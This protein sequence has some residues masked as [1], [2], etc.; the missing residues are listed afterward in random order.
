MVGRSQSDP[1]HVVSLDRKSGRRKAA[2]LWDEIL[3]M[4]M[5]GHSRLTGSRSSGD[6]LA[7]HER[8]P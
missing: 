1:Y 7:Q 5:G 6:T 4:T 3:P 2:R 8:E